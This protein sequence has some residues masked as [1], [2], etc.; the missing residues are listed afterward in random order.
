MICWNCTWV[1]QSFPSSEVKEFTVFFAWAW[2]VF[3]IGCFAKI[4]FKTLKKN[5]PP[6]C[7]RVSKGNW[8]WRW[9]QH[10]C[11]SLAVATSELLTWTVG[12]QCADICSF[13]LRHE[14]PLW[15]Y[16][17]SDR[18]HWHF[19]RQ[20]QRGSDYRWLGSKSQQRLQPP[21]SVQ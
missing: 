13:K 10:L 6:C 3:F 8:K 14:Q 16:L 2:G 9:Q 7:E 17:Q 21:L 18:G 19:H 15:R 4:S 1:T 12:A 20:N 11:W 5:Q